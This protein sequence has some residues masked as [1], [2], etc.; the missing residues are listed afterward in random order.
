MKSGWRNK[1]EPT[2]TKGTRY[3]FFPSEKASIDQEHS[4]LNLVEAR[5]A[6]LQKNHYQI[7]SIK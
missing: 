3:L 7:I 4:F 5:N 1:Q 2:K 6:V